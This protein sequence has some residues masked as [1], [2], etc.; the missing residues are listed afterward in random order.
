LDHRK[1]ASL[2]YDMMNEK[3]KKTRRKS[4]AHPESLLWQKPDLKIFAVKKI[5][6]NIITSETYVMIH[7]FP[8]NRKSLDDPSW[9]WRKTACSTRPGEV[10]ERIGMPRIDAVGM[11]PGS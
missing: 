10:L 5:L 8:G 7:L 9:P 3:K 6:I 1:E 11:R 2:I 4:Y